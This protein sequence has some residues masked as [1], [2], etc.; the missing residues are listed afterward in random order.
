M[1][2]SKCAKDDQAAQATNE[3][4]ETLF[5]HIDELLNRTLVLAPPEMKQVRREWNTAR[6]KADGA[7]YKQTPGKRR[8]GEMASQRRS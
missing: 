2:D 1:Q 5:G 3:G 7:T 6:A 4:A 8:T